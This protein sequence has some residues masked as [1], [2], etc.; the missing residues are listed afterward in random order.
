M[1]GG[2]D[3]GPGDR[4]E[5]VRDEP[6]AWREAAGGAGPGATVAAAAG[7]GRGRAVRDLQ[8]GAAGGR[9]RAL[10]PQLLRPLPADRAR[11]PGL[12]PAAAAPALPRLPRGER[13]PRLRR[14]AGAPGS[15]GAGAGRRLPGG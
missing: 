10:R 6:G 11:R 9:E 14:P 4:W 5:L 3:G 15:A 2:Y 7:P 8:G 1:A 13:H 12:G